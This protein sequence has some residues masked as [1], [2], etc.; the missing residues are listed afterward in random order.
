MSN[1]IEVKKGDRFGRLVVVKELKQHIQPSGK[2]RRMFFCLCDCGNKKKVGL[3][4]LRNRHTRSCG[5]L[6]AEASKE[7]FYIHGKYDFKEYRILSS[8]KNR[9]YNKKS[10]NYKNY[11]GRGIKICERWMKFENFYE[12]MGEKP[13]G[14]SLDRID[15]DGNYCKEN[16]RWATSSEQNI[17]KRNNV[18]LEHKGENLTMSQ[19]ANKLGFKQT[20]LSSRIFQYGWGVNKALTKSIRKKKLKRGVGVQTKRN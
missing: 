17:N 11:G 19:W 8:M 5:C 3:D 10:A 20:T 2:K 18:Y 1:K 7:R 15:N 12:D 16:C 9:C 6:N 13:E 14:K 4:C